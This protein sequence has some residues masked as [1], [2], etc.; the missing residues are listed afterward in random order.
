MIIGEINSKTSTPGS[1]FQARFANNIVDYENNILLSKT[2]ILIGKILDRTKAKY[3]LNNGSILFELSGA[4]LLSTRY[5][6]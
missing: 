4:H 2:T 5:A 3:L 1:M 6:G